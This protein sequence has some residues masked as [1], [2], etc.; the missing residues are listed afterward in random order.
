MQSSYESDSDSSVGE[1]PNFAAKALLSRNGSRK[2]VADSISDSNGDAP[3][4][5][6]EGVALEV[7]PREL[8]FAEI[9][10]ASA[11]V[12]VLRLRNTSLLPQ[13]IRVSKPKTKHFVLDYEPSGPIAPGLEI[14][15]RITCRV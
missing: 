8:S 10:P 13:R 12:A 3:F 11:Y 1:A 15:A 7:E 9:Q 14:T 4:H 2:K 5:A 6:Q